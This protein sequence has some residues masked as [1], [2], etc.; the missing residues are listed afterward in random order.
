MNS[1]QFI[2]KERLSIMEEESNQ[3]AEIKSPLGY[4]SFWKNVDNLF[5][6]DN[7]SNILNKKDLLLYKASKFSILIIIFS[8]STITF[9]TQ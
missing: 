2:S 4:L 8:Y 3:L 5:F 6:K 1:I 9:E 7:F